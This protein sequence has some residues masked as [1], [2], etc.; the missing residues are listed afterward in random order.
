MT[1]D[2]LVVQRA[3]GIGRQLGLLGPAPIELHVRHARG[4][5]EVIGGTA[6][7]RLLDLGSGAGVPGLLL[8][9]MLAD[10]QVVLLDSN[11]RRTEFLA[12]TVAELG[13]GDRVTVLRGRAED[14]AQ[15]TEWRE[16][17]DVVVA[18]SFGPP[19]NTAE[20]GA[21]LVRT[22]GVMVVSDPPLPDPPHPEPGTVD[23]SGADAG[24]WPTKGLSA[25]GLSP[26]PGVVSQGF[27]FQVLDKVAPCPSRYPRRSGLPRQRPLF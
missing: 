2:L 22:G 7:Q 27:S 17:Q 19:A 18:R 25:L 11:L 15:R 13:L 9:A 26:R 21:G 4:F 20:C 6:P 16:T 14:V 1:D 5:L 10:T 23:G 12:R 3:L 8:A 24:R